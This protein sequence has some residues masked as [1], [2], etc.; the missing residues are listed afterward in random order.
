MISATSGSRAI[1]VRSSREPSTTAGCSEL[2]ISASETPGIS[3]SPVSSACAWNFFGTSRVSASA[4]CG[5]IPLAR[6]TSLIADLESI[7]PKVA[8]WAT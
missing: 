4:S 6:A 5:G 7:V 1:A 2:I 3:V 8:I